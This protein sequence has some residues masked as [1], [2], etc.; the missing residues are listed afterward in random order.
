MK[1]FMIIMCIFFV[2]CGS[3]NVKF[4]I[5]DEWTDEEAL[6]IME[7]GRRWNEFA[8][9]NVIVFEGFSNERGN[10]IRKK[11]PN[12]KNFQSN[13]RRLATYMGE[14]GDIRVDMPSDENVENEKFILV[15]MH[16]MGHALGLEHVSFRGDLMSERYNSKLTGFTQ[17]D[18][19][20]CIKVGVCLDH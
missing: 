2:G 3:P 7:A 5:S 6:K 13:T 18:L 4:K 14:N 10:L 9:Q 17:N 20:E 19:R 1:Y 12:E 8:H 15:L 11:M 16:E